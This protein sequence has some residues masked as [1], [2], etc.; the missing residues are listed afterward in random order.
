VIFGGGI[1]SDLLWFRQNGSNL[2]VSVIGTNDKVSISSWYTSSNN[3]LDQFQTSDGKVLLES[4][5]QN[6][7]N[8]MAGFGVPAGGESNLTQDQRQQLEVVIAANWQ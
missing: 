7:V 8:A 6:L 3:H 1:T 4:Q 5:V 2:D